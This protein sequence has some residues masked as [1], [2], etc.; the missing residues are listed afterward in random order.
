MPK[1]Y[2][3]KD[4]NRVDVDRMKVVLLAPK[5]HQWQGWM[6]LAEF[7]ANFKEVTAPPP[8]K[9]INVTLD[10]AEDLVIPCYSNGD[11]WN[12]WVMPFFL[13]E[14]AM[15]IV[16]YPGKS[17]V[18]YLPDGD[19]FSSVYPGADPEDEWEADEIEVDG[20]KLKVYAVG[21]GFW[22]WAEVPTEV[23]DD[24]SP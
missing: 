15:K 2:E 18:V 9:V 11:R 14:D 22:T 3:D 23:F 4:G 13:F 16:A 8:Y 24:D 6:P 19:K 17:S 12:G 7:L 20:K 10:G 5:R 21:S 1:L